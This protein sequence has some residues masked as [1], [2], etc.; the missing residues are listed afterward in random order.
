MVLIALLQSLTV[1]YGWSFTVLE[2][3]EGLT[4]LCTIFVLVNGKIGPISLKSHR[5][6]GKINSG[7]QEVEKKRRPVMYAQLVITLQDGLLS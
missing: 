1:L 5:K 7:S 2:S 4:Q 3:H 6:S